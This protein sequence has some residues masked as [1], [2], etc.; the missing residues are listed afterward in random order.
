MRR[1]LQ[2][3]QDGSKVQGSRDP[4]MEQTSPRAQVGAWTLRVGLGGSKQ[5]HL[6]LD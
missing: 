1:G 4:S 5:E 3:L 2:A 6:H